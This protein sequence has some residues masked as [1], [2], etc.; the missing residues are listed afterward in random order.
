M[1]ALKQDQLTELIW[2]ASRGRYGYMQAEKIH[3]AA[4]RSVGMLRGLQGS[5]LVI[6]N[7]ISQIEAW[8]PIR[9]ALDLQ[10]K[11][12]AEQVPS[13]ILTLPGAAPFSAVSLYGETDPIHAFDGPARLVAYAGLDMPVYQTGQYQ[14]PRRHISKRGSPYL[15]KT[16]W[17]M[18]HRACYQEGDLRDYWLKKRS[19]GL[20]H[21]AAVTAVTV[22]LCRVAWRI[23]TDARDFVPKQEQQKS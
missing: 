1:L 19:L 15:R 23:M 8:I 18:A 3:L 21:L 13:H 2:K 14:A 11:N 6:P 16:L 17:T 5:R 12:L 7:L 20:H 22:K 10:I 9:K 4:K